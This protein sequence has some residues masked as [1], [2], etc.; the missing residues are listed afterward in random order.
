MPDS[1][2]R[3]CFASWE[4]SDKERTARGGTQRHG[5][6]RQ[7]DREEKGRLLTLEED[8]DGR[9]DRYYHDRDA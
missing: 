5:A 4:S 1:L 6:G 7:S 9:D 2:T 3:F 8:H